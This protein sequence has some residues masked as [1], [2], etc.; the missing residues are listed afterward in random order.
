MVKICQT[1]FSFFLKDDIPF[2]FP[3]E[4][5]KPDLR[6]HIHV[7]VYLLKAFEVK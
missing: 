3:M 4:Q 7:Q 6:G 1:V 5:L 2:F